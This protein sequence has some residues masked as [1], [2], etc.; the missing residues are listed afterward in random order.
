MVEYF[1]IQLD[2]VFIIG[3]EKAKQDDKFEVLAYLACHLAISDIFCILLA[4]AA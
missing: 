4:L 1:E 2:Y 3:V